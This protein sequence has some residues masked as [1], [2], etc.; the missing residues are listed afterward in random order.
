[1]AIKW[2]N[3]QLQAIEDSNK[4][5]LVSAAAG[6]GKTT[7]L[8]ERVIKKLLSGQD[9]DSLL[10]VTFTR[11]AAKEMKD[12]LINRL[13]KEI[14]D[15]SSK[16][17]KVHLQRQLVKI[18]SA[19]ISTIHAFCSN[20]IKKFYYLIDLDPKYR[21]MTDQTEQE[22]LKEKAWDLIRN[23]YYKENDADFINL[24]KN[25]SNDR[26]DDGMQEIIFKL[27][28]FAITSPDSNTW[29][30]SLSN[31]Y[32]L[33]NKDYANSGI[34]LN[35]ILPRIQKELDNQLAQ[36]KKAQSITLENESCEKFVES[37][38]AGI[39]LLQDIINNITQINF[40]DIGKRL[41]DFK[42]PRAKTIKD[43][44][45]P[46]SATKLVT[47]IRKSITSTITKK[48]PDELII[49]TNDVVTKLMNHSYQ[50][51]TKL[52]IVEKEFIELFNKLKLAN[53]SLDFSDLEHFTVD[54]L[55]SKENDE[56]IA[57]EYYQYKF[58]EIMID[59][60]QDVNPMQENIIQTLKTQT[61][62]L[63]MVGDIK[64]SIYGFRQAAPYLFSEKYDDF[65]T[66]K[67]NNEVILLSNNFRSSKS[68]TDFVNNTFTLIMDRQLGGVNYDRASELI[69]GTV[70]PESIDSQTEIDLINTTT[71]E[72]NITNRDAQINFIASKINFLITSGFQI[73][74]AKKDETRPIRYSDISILSR[75]K[76]F[77]TDIISIFSK[78]GIPVFVTDSQNY[79]QTMEI[80]V[81]LEFLRII[82]NPEQDIALVAVLRSPIVNLNE[83]DLASIH[84]E[85]K[86]LNFYES[87]LAYMQNHEDE[88]SIKLTTF[89]NNLDDLTNLSKQVRISELIWEIYERTGF[90]DFV[91]GMPGGKQR[92][93]NLHAL[94][95]RASQFEEMNFKGIFKFIRFIERIEENKKDLSQPNSVE[96]GEDAVSVMTIHGSKGLE[97]PVVFLIDA[98]KKFN[99][100]DYTDATLIDS[101]LGIGL[102]VLD[103]QQR[104]IYS[105]PIR[106][107]IANK[108]IEST[109]SEELR[110]LY[111]ALTRAKQK[112]FI[113]GSD[114][115]TAA[116][117][118]KWENYNIENN[119]VDLFD[120]L[121]Y[122]NYLDMIMPVL[123]DTAEKYNDSTY[124]NKYMNTQVNL[125]LTPSSSE[126]TVSNKKIE[127]LTT[128]T[129]D[130]QLFS[131]TVRNILEFNYPFQGSIKT[132]AY[133]SVS[134]IKYLFSDPDEDILEK[135]S[136]ITSGKYTLNDFSKPKFLNKNIKVSAAEIGSATHL[137]LQKLPLSTKPTLEII[138]S[139]IKQLVS[140]DIISKSVAEK[141]DAQSLVDFY[142]SK[143]GELIFN[144]QASLKREYPFSMVI[145][146]P[147][148]FEDT[149][150]TDNIL[151]HGII[152]GVIETQEG[153][154][155]F[156]YKTD[157]VVEDDN[158][159]NSLTSATEKYSGQLNLYSS[160]IQSIE[161][162]PVIGKYLYF[163]KLGKYVKI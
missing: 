156:D 147:K 129:N 161:K 101:S 117:I 100:S 99:N 15:A 32:D 55:N 154:I 27:Y 95:Q 152:D 85:N 137:I 16:E 88:L 131:N 28:N 72:E 63:F 46:D 21:L 18:P 133:Q 110:L 128:S 122:K 116:K 2:T 5:I 109:I 42:L 78:S 90:L 144:N 115:D 34:Y 104:L 31:Y 10:I 22:L 76:G 9:I 124:L 57:S 23:K 113:V 139:L 141:V 59:E 91:T 25:F 66:S 136:V 155:I 142:N 158:A 86:Q 80:Q 153:I 38:D 12:R 29:L 150:K 37:N 73:Y 151:I 135:S 77:N 56:Y 8:I 33:K 54:I 65:T 62:N 19:D 52:I 71:D 103:Q 83:N 93:A 58:S 89:F 43:G 87:S 134:E 64:Q 159:K 47:D 157:N 123:L 30:D 132:T 79:F 17:I 106:S 118:L 11:L 74:D 111:V 61:N 143:L 94:Y 44:P 130:D 145:P 107:I 140:N 36:L 4:D 41:T 138:N 6:S 69:P 40:D 105:T 114:K 163:L 1:M 162:K 121:S 112:L 45:K 148:I 92:S 160:A 125:I 60:Y 120:R 127:L 82:D 70:F 97:F 50:L 126:N 35:I 20:V 48:I 149:D 51:V 3:Q 146:A 119:K 26:N 53:K 84:L 24:T 108:K 7:I 49:A 98:N 102:K 67:D 39:V 14:N 68:V 75:S 13:R 96:A 81:M